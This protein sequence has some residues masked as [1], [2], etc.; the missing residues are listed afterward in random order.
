M[1]IMPIPYEL[2]CD[3]FVLLSPN[4][5]GF[6][7]TFIDNV[8]IVK[9]SVISDYTST[10]MRDISELVVYYDCERST[11]SGVSFSAGEQAQLDG[12][13]AQL[14][15]ELY[16]LLKAELFSGECPHHYKLTFRKIG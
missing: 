12:E 16:E 8:R 11:P 15:G 14:D 9:R 6:S 13:Q 10:R 7:R 2:L 1:N 4:E 3:S 5:S